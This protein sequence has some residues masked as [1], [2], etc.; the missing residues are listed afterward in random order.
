MNGSSAPRYRIDRLRQKFIDEGGVDSLNCQ[1]KGCHNPGAA[2]AHV[3]KTD[4]R[5]NND[6]MLCWVCA[7]HNNHHNE[8]P[9]ALR[10]NAHLI[11]VRDITE[12]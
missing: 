4:G 1:V 8:E 5:S 6:W 3:I 7:A 2:T 12:N 9:Y 10:A 11:R